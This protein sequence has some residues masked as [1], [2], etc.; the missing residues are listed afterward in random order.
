MDKT[1]QGAHRVKKVSLDG[2]WT[3]TAFPPQHERGFE[4]PARVPGN[5]EID[6]E[7]AG[8]IADPFFGDNIRG[9]RK[10]EFYAWRYARAFTAPKPGKGERAQLFFGGVD[11]FA[12][13]VLNGHEIGRS[14]NALVEHA[15]DATDALAEGENRLEVFIDSPILR[16]QGEPLEGEAFALAVN[17]ESLRVR[18]APSCYGW[19]IMPRTVSAGLW[20]GVELR[21]VGPNEVL[22]IHAVVLGMSEKTA[23]L[24]LQFHIQTDAAYFEGLSLRVRGELDGET[25]FALERPIRFTAGALEIDVENPE[26]WWPRG[27]GRAALY[28]LT[29]ELVK[30]GAVAAARTQALGIRTVALERTEVTDERGGEFRFVVNGR[31]ILCKGT[32]WVPADALHSRDAGRVPAMLALLADTGCNMVRCWGGNVYEDHAFFDICDREGILVWQDFAMACGVYPQDEA[33]LA[34][35]REE[36]EKVVKKLRDHPSLILWSGDNENDIV[37]AWHMKIDPNQNRVTREVLP[38]V[39][40]RL[41]PHRPYL[42]SS[43]YISPEAWARG[44][45]DILPENHLWGPRDYF[46]SAYYTQSSAHFVSEQGYHG[47]PNLSSMKRFLSPERL[48]PW[49]NNPEWL[50][51]AAEH[52][53]PDG[54]YAYRVKLIADQTAELFGT[55][56]D[57]LE[58]FILA[59]Q[60]SQAE[61][62]KFFIEL[63]R[64][65]KWRR[66]GILW[67]NMI[68][69][70]PQF[71]DAVVD[72]YFSKKLAY[73]YIKRS[74][75]P[76]CLMMAEPESWHCSLVAGNDTLQDASGAFRVWDG[77]TGETVLEGPFDAP[78]NQSSVIG[79]VR[80]SHG[81]HR[82]Y[83]IAWEAGGVRGVNH[84]ALGKP[85]F[86]LT[87]YKTWLTGIAALDGSFEAGKVGL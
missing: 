75:A 19:D 5:V 52:I 36:A 28:A 7:R 42:P 40:R 2:L 21:M 44:S 74:Q 85:P 78:A 26:L 12:R 82:L 61:A 1:K 45:T 27:Y 47:M 25:R 77:E 18:K 83:L 35:I 87:T 60:I 46:K 20:R 39:V 34:A 84:Y 43:P 48:W 9:L 86:D 71:S 38:Q 53:G 3:L 55:A 41:D 11:C 37:G 13:I 70:W 33:F 59:S 4:I 17:H 8:L 76:L 10:T 80:V 79:R 23:H 24:C 22:D 62:K 31:P 68:D 16:V 64:V 51:H 6:M 14:E 29:A 30:D 50:A 57:N 49:E 58:D 56:P 32:N 15:F 66:T 73:H 72:Y 67:W 54:P 81:A 65:K 69:G 63:T